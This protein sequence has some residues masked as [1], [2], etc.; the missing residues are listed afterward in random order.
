MT[1][2]GLVDRPW[3]PTGGL[4]KGYLGG[5]VWFRESVS[6]YIYIFANQANGEGKRKLAEKRP[7]AKFG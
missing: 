6:F 2:Q 5:S 1:Q 7:L 4:D 3:V